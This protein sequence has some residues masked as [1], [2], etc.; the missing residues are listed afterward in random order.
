MGWLFEKIRHKEGLGFGDVKM[1]A[2]IGSF[3]GLQGALLTVVLGSLLGSIIGFTWIKL[4]GKDA[5]E[6]QLPFATFLGIAGL[7]IAGTG[8]AGV[9]I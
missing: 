4:T 1:I 5:A 3:L 7:V 9:P 2:M 6:Y 8:S